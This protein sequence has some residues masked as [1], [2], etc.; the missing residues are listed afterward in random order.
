[1]ATLLVVIVTMI[2]PSTPLGQILGFSQL[3]I[4]FSLLIGIVI[5]AYIVTAEVAKTIFYK[6]VKF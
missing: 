1:M 2:F 6:K 4:S 5:M 3:P